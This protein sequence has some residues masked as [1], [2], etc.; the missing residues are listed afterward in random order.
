MGTVIESKARDLLYGEA[1]HLYW[2]A[3]AIAGASLLG[4]VYSFVRSLSDEMP[5]RRWRIRPFV[6]AA[7]MVVAIPPIAWTTTMP[8]MIIREF[9]DGKTHGL[10]QLAI[11]M[12]GGSLLALVYSIAH[13]LVI[14]M[15]IVGGTRI[16]LHKRRD[17]IWA[18]LLLGAPLALI[19]LGIPPVDLELWPYLMIAG[20][21]AAALNWQ[22]VIR[23][24]RMSRLTLGAPQPLPT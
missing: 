23:P 1:V 2:L 22:I 17:S 24:L 18:S 16:L 19:V 11:G 21:A 5:D 12:A 8:E 13:S 20:S 3:I 14:T 4:I 7:V 6:A 10:W 15:A 9:L